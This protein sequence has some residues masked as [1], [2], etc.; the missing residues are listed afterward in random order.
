MRIGRIRLQRQVLKELVLPNKME[1]GDTYLRF[2]LM[3]PSLRFYFF[4]ILNLATEFP[5][6]TATR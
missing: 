2:S 1:N 4:T 5:V 6:I 3:T